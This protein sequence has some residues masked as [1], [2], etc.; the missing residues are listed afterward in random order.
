[1][2]YNE[3]MAHMRNII[4]AGTIGIW[5]SLAYASIDATLF[6]QFH[7]AEPKKTDFYV[8]EGVFNGGDR[9]TAPFSV[10]SLRFAAGQE[11]ERLVFDVKPIMGLGIHELQQAPYFEV[12]VDSRK[13][14]ILVTLFGTSDI[15]LNAEKLAKA[16][17]KSRF[18]RSVE[19]LPKVEDDR[20]SF[21]VQLN[22]ARPI[23][24]FELTKPAR[25]VI[26]IKTRGL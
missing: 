11:H 4:L 9:A 10:E 3:D 18:I 20:R 19:A 24:V 26:D 14:Q 7:L 5:G 15:E 25:I 17:R 2:A 21:F 13:K 22:A 16:F 6:E 1:M 8:R 12:A 23:E